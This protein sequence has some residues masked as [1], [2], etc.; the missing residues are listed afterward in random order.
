MRKLGHA[1]AEIHLAVRLVV[2]FCEPLDHQN[3]VVTPC[4]QADII[5]VRDALMLDGFRRADLI[6]HAVIVA[7]TKSCFNP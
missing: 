3:Q 6:V 1:H 4:K 5:D 2:A 7:Q